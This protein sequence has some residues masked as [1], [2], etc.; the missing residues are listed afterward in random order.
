[1]LLLSPLMFDDE[2]LYFCRVTSGGS[3]VDS[4]NATLSGKSDALYDS[5]ILSWYSEL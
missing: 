1:M 3:I 5:K 2:G 4:N